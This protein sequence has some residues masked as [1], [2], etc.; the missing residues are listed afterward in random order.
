MDDVAGVEVL[1]T[2]TDVFHKRQSHLS[3]QRVV[4]IVN[5]ITV[6]NGV[7]SKEKR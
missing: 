5:Q 3:R 4:P 7:I 2:A 6:M 1:E